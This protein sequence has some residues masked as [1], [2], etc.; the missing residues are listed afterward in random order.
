MKK[1]YAV[2]AV[3]LAMLCCP[4]QVL[5]FSAVTI[6]RA[7]SS[8]GN[9]GVQALAEIAETVVDAL[10]NQ[11]TIYGYQVHIWFLAACGAGVLLLLIIVVCAVRRGRRRRAARRKQQTL[12]ASVSSTPTIY[13]V[14]ADANW[15]QGPR[16]ETPY[17]QRE[18]PK[19]PSMPD[20]QG[21]VWEI[22]KMREESFTAGAAGNRSAVAKMV[23]DYMT[24]GSAPCRREF[25][26]PVEISIGRESSNSIVVNYAGVSPRHALIR[27]EGN[28]VFLSNVSEFRDGAQND[29]Y[30]G[31]KP[32]GERMEISNGCHFDVGMVPMTVSWS[33]SQTAQSPLMTA[34]DIAQKAVL[35]DAV[36]PV[37]F[38][39]RS[40][41]DTVRVL[42]II[43]NVSW[44]IGHQTSSK[45]VTLDREISIGRDV[46]DT[47]VINDPQ[48]T[49]S[50]HHIVIMRQG[51]ELMVKNGSRMDS[52]M[53]K[54]PFIYQGREIRDGVPFVS[55]MTV[56][57]GEAIVKIERE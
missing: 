38:D 50:R 26:N 32:V 9:S 28:S 31:G 35:K 55:G 27:C 40:S 53:G 44:L 8:E 51:N 6:V 30:V 1:W 22:G 19:Q 46:Q 10:K 2:L 17:G 4:L 15:S 25:M 34:E 52:A 47:V 48:K 14:N 24:P 13:S 49:V 37:G 39:M 16:M 54:N 23:V 57:L 42:P 11:V 45:R 18:T 36:K 56:R 21:V 41:E 33:F 7:E 43:L 3:C 29:L 12:E 20:V 5:K